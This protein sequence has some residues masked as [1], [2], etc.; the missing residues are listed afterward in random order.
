MNKRY[1]IL[2]CPLE[3]GLG[4]AARMIPLASRLRE[5]NN[6]VFIGAGEEHLAL[7][8][9]E[10]PELERIDFP[11][12]HPGYSKHLPQ[13]LALLLKTPILLYHIIREHNKLKKIIREFEIDIVISDNRFGLWNKKVRT[14][15]VT[16]MLRI[17]FPGA[18][19]FLEFIGIVLHRAIINKYDHCFIPDLPG[20]LNVSGIL[21]HA[22]SLPVNA[23]YIGLLSRFSGTRPA[24]VENPVN[25][26]HNCVI[27]SG[28]EPQRSILKQKLSDALR[29]NDIP[30]VFLG[31]M[32]EKEGETTRSGNIIWFSHLPS[33]VMKAVITGS[34]III[35]RSGYTTI[36]ELIS[37]NCSA[38]LIPT[39]GQTEQEYL[40]HY[41]EEKGWFTA[42]RQKLIREGLVLSPVK[43]FRSEEINRQSKVLLDEALTVL[44]E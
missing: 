36:M 7:F 34:E 42:V 28:P 26:R 6:R 20:D 25:Y 8:R 44:L 11:G 10:L 39:P 14:V 27:L 3:W 29:D 31:G 13:Y 38:L 18:L 19:I 5:M 33:G 21:S 9:S 24:I 41:L 37:L 12:F 15:Y 30:T 16:H 35:S 32:P 2:I 22:V 23:R 43:S 4:H 40:A 17:P 1:N